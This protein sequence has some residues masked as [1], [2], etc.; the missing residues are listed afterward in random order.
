MGSLKRCLLYLCV[1]YKYKFFKWIIYAAYAAPVYASTHHNDQPYPYGSGSSKK[2]PDVIQLNN[3]W[4][5]SIKPHFSLS[6]T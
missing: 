3:C 6:N 5:I 2:T 4:S 1:K